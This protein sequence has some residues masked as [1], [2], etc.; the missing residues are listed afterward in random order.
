LIQNIKRRW[1]ALKR[2]E[3]GRRFQDEYDKRHG[4]NS[5]RGRKIGILVAGAIVFAEPPCS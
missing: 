5:S 3:P 4:E 2:G 1:Q